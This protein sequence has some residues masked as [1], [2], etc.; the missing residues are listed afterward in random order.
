MTGPL[1][2]LRIV[3]IGDDS[4]AYAGRLFAGFGADVVRLTAPAGLTVRGWQI[5]PDPVVQDFLHRGKHTLPLPSDPAYRVRRIAQVIDAA[6]ILIESGAPDVLEQLGLTEDDPSIQR[7][8]LIRVRVTPW[9]TGSDL[10]LMPG[11]DLISSAAGGFLTLGGWPDR[12]PTRAFGD[13]SLRMASLH[14]AVGAMLAVLARDRDGQ[15]QEVEVGV[16]ES[17]ATALENS[18]QYA[19]LEDVI[20]RRT[21]P[22]YQEA[23]SGVYSCQDGFLYVMVGR[24]STAQGW[25]NLTAWLREEGVDGAD[26]LSSDEWADYEFR[27]SS[28]AKDRFREVFE[29]FASRWAK[30][31]LYVQAQRR[32]IAIC[33]IN[34]PDDLLA[35]EHL[36]ARGFFTD[37]PDG[38][39]HVG[40]PFR[41]SVT[42]W[43]NEV[44]QEGAA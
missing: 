7:A 38:V 32:G 18:L 29:R 40:A 14:A 11:S 30:A 15:G 41:M 16:T 1:S 17:V 13:Q 9:G 42:P 12:A 26:E 25:Q 19:D 8:D 4:G 35:S 10:A 27:K 43:S 21:G 44:A 5:D 37:G 33:P 31:D 39:R 23:G 24:L 22:G 34:S 2:H 36:N 3:E 28:Y 20:R 6:D